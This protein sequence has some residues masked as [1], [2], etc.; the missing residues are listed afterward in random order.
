MIIEVRTPKAILM[1][2]RDGSPDVCDNTSV[3]DLKEKFR[4]GT[5]LDD[6]TT[7]TETFLTYDNW[8]SY[9][10][11]VYPEDQNGKRYA[12]FYTWDE[13][14]QADIADVKEFSLEDEDHGRFPRSDRSGRADRDID[15]TQTSIS[16]LETTR[17]A[18]LPALPFEIT[19]GDETLRVTNRTATSDDDRWIYTVV[20]GVE[21]PAPPLPPTPAAFAQDEH[22]DVALVEDP[23]I[24]RALRRPC[25][26]GSPTPASPESRPPRRSTARPAG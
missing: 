7:F 22:S 4:F 17:T 19:I 13:K 9:N 11:I 14:R 25:S 26:K 15:A 8:G 2:Y 23:A 18:E 1:R 21:P 3:T 10:R 5:S 6:P 16:V 20:R 24:R 12:V